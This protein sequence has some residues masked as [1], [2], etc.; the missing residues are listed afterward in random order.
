MEE[1]KLDFF[2]LS[3]LMSFIGICRLVKNNIE[4]VNG[5]REMVEET[6]EQVDERT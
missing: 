1:K 4:M 2:S 6:S 3:L 5:M